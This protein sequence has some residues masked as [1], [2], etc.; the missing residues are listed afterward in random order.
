[1]HSAYPA[2]K[3]WV[4]ISGSS[5]ID[6]EVDDVN[7]IAAFTLDFTQAVQLAD[8]LNAWVK[9]QQDAYAADLNTM[10]AC[11]TNDKPLVQEL[12]SDSEFWSTLSDA[13][14]QQVRDIA[15]QLDA[16]TGMWGTSLNAIVAVMNPTR[17]VQP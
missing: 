8:W 17:K 13:E 3:L 14:Q 2:Q 1:M 5:S 12:L 9:T 10:A 6:I 11:A 7:A 16:A 4:G 15:S